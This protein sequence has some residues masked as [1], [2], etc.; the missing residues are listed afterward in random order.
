MKKKPKQT[1][2]EMLP[3]YDLTKLKRVPNPFRHLAGKMRHLV[4][5]DPDLWP[6]FGSAAAVNEALRAVVELS[7]SVRPGK[8]T[9]RRRA[10]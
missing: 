1:S 4:A 9:R 5:I 6:H 3:E 10:A 8:P 2:D 7:K